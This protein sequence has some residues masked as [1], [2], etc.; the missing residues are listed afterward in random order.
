MEAGGCYANRPTGATTSA[1]PGM[2]PFG[3]CK[4]LGAM[5][6]NDQMKLSLKPITA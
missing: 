1:W 4:A 2:Q 3:G 6:K 5:G